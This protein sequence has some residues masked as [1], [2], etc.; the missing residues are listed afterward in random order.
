MSYCSWPKKT[1]SSW[2]QNKS[3]SLFYYLFK[4]F[5]SK[6]IVM[7][8]FT[9]GRVS[10]NRQALTCSNFTVNMPQFLN[11]KILNKWLIVYFKTH[12]STNLMS[13]QPRTIGFS[14]LFNVLHNFYAC[15]RTLSLCGSLFKIF[16]FTQIEAC[17]QC[18]A[19]VHVQLANVWEMRIYSK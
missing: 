14:G 11:S 17:W 18:V 10:N 19:Q 2:S 15:E 1:S 5:E 4:V 6:D 12:F 8:T 7:L 13:L 3:S 9:S 16:A